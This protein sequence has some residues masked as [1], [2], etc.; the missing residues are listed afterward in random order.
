[1]PDGCSWALGRQQPAS[2]VLLE[3]VSSPIDPASKISICLST[4]GP[5]SCVSHLIPQVDIMDKKFPPRKSFESDRASELSSVTNGESLT[6]DVQVS[7]G[8]SLQIRGY[9]L[10]KSKEG[11]WQ[12]RFF[13]TNGNYLTYYKTKRMTKLLAALSL[14]DVGD[15]SV[16]SMK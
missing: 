15:I 9:L 10:K 1:M 2:A 13:E 12:K 5:F 14:S 8:N 11:A 7:E 6:D 3:L 16:V 4:A